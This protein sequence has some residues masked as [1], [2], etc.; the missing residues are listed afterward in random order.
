M[1]R[2]FL[3]LLAFVTLVSLAGCTTFETHTVGTKIDTDMV[4]T[5]D[6]GTTTRSEIINTFGAPTD[7]TTEGDTERM[8]F[9]YEET[10]V[11]VY[12]GSIKNK[13]RTKKIVT[14]LEVIF[15]DDIVSNYKFTGTEEE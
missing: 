8:V 13:S 1:K 10:K 9:T 2:D 3:I 11:P 7:V 15:K 4:A 6:P 14:T 5:I 12:M